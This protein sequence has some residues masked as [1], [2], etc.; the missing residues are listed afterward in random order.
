MS[1]VPPGAWTYT[2]GAG[3]ESADTWF[4]NTLGWYDTPLRGNYA[5]YAFLHEIGHSVGLKHG[6]EIAVQNCE[7]YEYDGS[8]VV[9]SD[10]D[11]G[12]SRVTQPI[13][14]CGD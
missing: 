10:L 2:I 13:V 1:D 6:N 11:R 12:D 8:Q 7:V 14:V 4:G 3:P 9:D 5:S